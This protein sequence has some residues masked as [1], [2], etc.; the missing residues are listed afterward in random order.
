MTNQRGSTI[1][2]MITALSLAGILTV[3][4][5]PVI[6]A[7]RG[8]YELA[9]ATSQLAFEISRARMQ[10]IGQNVFVRLRIVSGNLVR[11]R[12]ANGVLYVQDGAAIG[13]P[14]KVTATAGASGAPSFDRNG[15][16]SARTAITVS[17]SRGRKT[18]QTSVVGR[19]TVS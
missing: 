9:S 1:A 17:N 14:G 2:E 4:A 10:A 11:E 18:V 8:Q 19:V 6:G 13:L 16:A 12:S 3:T 5:N 15:L 7:L